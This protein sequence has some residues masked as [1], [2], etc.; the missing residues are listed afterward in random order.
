MAMRHLLKR[1]AVK[2]GLVSPPA[3]VAPQKVKPEA[4]HPLINPH[5]DVYYYMNRNP[6]Y[7]G[8][9]I[10]DYTIGWADILDYEWAVDTMER[11]TEIRIG[12]FCNLAE[13]AKIFKGGNHRVDWLSTYA[14]NVLDP[15]FKH[16]KGHP[17]TNGDVIIGN[18]VWLCYGATVLSGVKIGDGAV[19]A[20]GSIVTSDVPPYAIVAGVPAKVIRM[21]FDESTVNYLLELKWWD[22]PYEKIRLIVPELMS[23][24]IEQL[25]KKMEHVKKSA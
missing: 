25:K 7:A 2:L 20:T 16:I 10:G 14:F 22:L 9:E 4:P 12:K 13:G 24:D 5:D 19:I 17:A 18:D 1:I 11:R 15:E 6:K 23:G 8:Y 3:P 21:R